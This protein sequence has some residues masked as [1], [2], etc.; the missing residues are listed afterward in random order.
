[1][2]YSESLHFRG[3]LLF[4]LAIPRIFVSA[5]ALVFPLAT[6]LTTSPQE[7]SLKL[8]KPNIAATRNSEVHVK[9]AITNTSNHEIRFAVAFGNH[10]F[11]YDVEITDADG[12]VPPLTP[13]FRHLKETSSWWGSY[14]TRILKPGESF[15]EDLVLTHLYKLEPGE[16]RVQVARSIRGHVDRGAKKI[17]SNVT[18]LTVSN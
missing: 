12:R 6:A 17:K 8:Q 9:T 7:F 18:R 10:E 11:D 2:K 16:Y 3:K 15:D 14:A 13:E 1:M 5:L 4:M